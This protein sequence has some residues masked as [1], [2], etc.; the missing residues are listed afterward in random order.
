[1]TPRSFATVFSGRDHE[2]VL[3]DGTRLNLFVRQL[4]AR[5]HVDFIVRQGNEADLL[6]FV[7]RPAVGEA[8]LEPGWAD[9]LSDKSHAELLSI[10]KEINLARAIATVER[11][12][13]VA[14]ML[15]PL[16]PPGQTS[17]T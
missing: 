2:A 5:F 13:A 10:A 8:P 16:Q 14:K 9:A 17:T 3:L 4:P 7:C 15:M 6:E 12:N 1:M 11:A